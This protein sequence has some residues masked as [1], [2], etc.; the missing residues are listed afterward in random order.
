MQ[1]YTTGQQL[2]FTWPTSLCYTG[3]DLMTPRQWVAVI[4]MVGIVGSFSLRLFCESACAFTH[5]AKG[6]MLCHESEQ[7]GTAVADGSECAEHTA[8]PALTEIRRATTSV[9][10]VAVPASHPTFE[11]PVTR[12]VAVLIDFT[13]TGPPA[14]SSIL[15]LRI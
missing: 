12:G 3:R 1:S 15:P 14:P 4:C 6:I 2:R 8:L 11:R 5:A 9:E 10:L 13:D 7:A